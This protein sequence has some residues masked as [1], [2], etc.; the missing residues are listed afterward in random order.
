MGPTGLCREAALS[1][2]QVCK[3]NLYLFS[4][5]LQLIIQ[6]KVPDNLTFTLR[7]H[8]RSEFAFPLWLCGLCDGKCFKH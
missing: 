1:T 4:I 6:I 2:V 8:L 3:M 5:F 7:S